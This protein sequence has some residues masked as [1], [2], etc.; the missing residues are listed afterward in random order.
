MLELAEL[1]HLDLQKL[2]VADFRHVKVLRVVAKQ[3]DYAHPVRIIL[4]VNFRDSFQIC[5]AGTLEDLKHTVT[6]QV[7]IKKIFQGP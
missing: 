5:V 4:G 3:V 7:L 2:V 6:W 1:L